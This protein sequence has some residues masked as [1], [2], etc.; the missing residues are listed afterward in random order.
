M[1]A[2]AERLAAP[3]LRPLPGRSISLTTDGCFTLSDG[4]WLALGKADYV[5]LS[6]DPASGTLSIKSS[7]AGAPG[8]GSIL[9]KV[10][11]QTSPRVAIGQ[12]IALYRLQDRLG[13][14]YPA[15]GQ[16]YGSLVVSLTDGAA[17]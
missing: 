11:R 13:C 6:Y 15:A 12:I 14:R 10:S 2:L 16:T 5:T 8:D 7:V 9:R 17:F 3:R 1:S 4:A